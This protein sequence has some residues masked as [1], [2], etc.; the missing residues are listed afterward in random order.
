MT[1]RLE[2]RRTIVVKTPSLQSAYPDRYWT[3][4]VSKADFILFHNVFSKLIENQLTNWPL[5]SLLLDLL[6]D[7]CLRAFRETVFEVIASRRRARHET[8]A[9]HKRN[10]KAKGV[11]W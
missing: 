1:F 6:L 8:T 3:V 4:V 10:T 2:H 11:Q 9:S 7:L 5:A